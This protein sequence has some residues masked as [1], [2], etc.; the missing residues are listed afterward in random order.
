MCNAQVKK[1]DDNDTLKSNSITKVYSNPFQ[2]ALEKNQNSIDKYYLLLQK[3]KS[4][5]NELDQ[6]V[7][8]LGNENDSLFQSLK[9]HIKI[10]TELDKEQYTNIEKKYI[11][12]KL[13][14]RIKNE[15][16]LINSIKIK[17]TRNQQLLKE[18]NNYGV[19]QKAIIKQKQKYQKASSE[20]QM[21][22]GKLVG[23]ISFIYNNEQYYGFVANLKIHQI[24]TYLRPKSKAPVF[25]SIKNLKA[26]VE[27]QKDT[28]L[29]ITNAGMYTSKQLPEGLLISKGKQLAPIDLGKASHL[30]FYLLPNGVFYIDG[31]KAFIAETHA[32]DSLSKKIKPSIATQSG[33]L[34]VYKGKHHHAFNY[35]SK[36]KKLRSGVGILPNGKVV[37]LISKNHNTNFFEFATI[38]KDVFGC[39]NALF[40]DGEISKMYL[41]NLNPEEL[42]GGFGPMISIT[43]KNK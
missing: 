42:G 25:S 11:D 43:M 37:F 33:P 22:S 38:F 18:Y 41:P 40:L 35:G 23:E 28:A 27:K 32:Y 13:D 12:K 24:N 30:N 21:V 2:E 9:K 36:S 3:V 10:K 19:L 39:Q 15:E 16:R 1:V 31:N 5:P 26:Y 8:M 20:I 7:E 6:K 4:I 14:S 17:I 34:L 29:M